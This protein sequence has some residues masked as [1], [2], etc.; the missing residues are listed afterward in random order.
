M[1]DAIRQHQSRRRL[2]VCVSHAVENAI[3]FLWKISPL[4][5]FIVRVCW[6]GLVCQSFAVDLVTASVNSNGHSL[7][8]RQYTA[9]CTV[10]IRRLLKNDW[11]S[12]GRHREA[13]QGQG[14]AIE[15]FDCDATMRICGVVSLSI[16]P[17]PTGTWRASKAA[18][19]RFSTAPIGNVSAHNYLQK[20]DSP[21]G[22]RLP[23][24]H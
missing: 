4:V 7:L 12:R 13:G 8:S 18:R 11:Q 14:T 3:K 17:S 22:Y 21:L 9:Q 24:C 6:N 20:S 1:A 15:C 10:Q 5:L 16:S 23:P 19:R 2:A